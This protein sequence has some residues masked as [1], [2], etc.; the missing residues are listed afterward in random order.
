MKHPF[1]RRARDLAAPPGVAPGR[2]I[3]LF[4][5]ASYCPDTRAYGYGWWVKYGAPAQT[6]TGHG[7]GLFIEN[8]THAE[9]HA[10]EAGLTFILGELDLTQR[11]VVVQSDCTGALAKIEAADWFGRLHALGAANAYTKHVHGHRGT[12]SPRHAV[13]TG[14]DRAARRCMR[15]FRREQLK[16]RE[17]V[18]A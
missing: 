13:N 18:D 11:I 3:T 7:G 2:Y 16:H 4:A 5:D 6:R 14:C 15:H 12:L 9:V 8:S 17:Q 10:L 1:L